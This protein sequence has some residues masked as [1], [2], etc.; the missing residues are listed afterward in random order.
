[1]SFR[2]VIFTPGQNVKPLFLCQYL[3]FFNDFFFALEISFGSFLKPK[4]RNLKKIADLK[5]Y[6]KGKQNDAR[7]GINLAFLGRVVHSRLS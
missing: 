6:G 1:M 5:V 7:L 4:T 3:I 2:R